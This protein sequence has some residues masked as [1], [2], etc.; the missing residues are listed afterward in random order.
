VPT[1]E[2]IC[3]ACNHEFE[4]FQQISE[5]PLRVCPKCR[6]RKL[7]RK[8]GSGAAVLFKGSGFYQTDYRGK[9]YH[10]DKAKA[11]TPASCE[12][13]CKGCPHSKKE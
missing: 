6:K 1:Y 13:K 3:E 5:K 2:Y 9:S 10:S 12:S 4:E 11:E 8:I 7:R